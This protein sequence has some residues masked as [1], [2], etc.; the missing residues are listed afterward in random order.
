[1]R[2]AVISDIHSNLEALGA[3]FK[4]A[5]RLGIGEVVCLGD[6]VGYNAS[7]NECIDLLRQ[8]KVR[9]IMGNHDSRAAGL[10][11][12]TG[13]SLLAAEAMSWTLRALTPESVE[14]L[15]DLPQTLDVDHA[16]LAVH[17]W[18]NDADEYIYSDADAG[19]NFRLLKETPF[20]LCFFGHTHS[21]M[22]YVEGYGDFDAGH[23]E[24]SHAALSRDLSYLINPGSIGQPR[25][26]DPRA[27]FIVFDSQGYSVEFHRIDYDI[28]GAAQRI[29]DA[30]LPKRLAERLRLGW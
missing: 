23:E 14:Y 19:M 7:P 17:G 21:P 18:I 15:K 24:D 29:I 5:D 11:D 22:V 20:K 1:M 26:S 4:A 3:F 16:F 13:F 6:V 27:S 8:R 10:K 28:R 2:Y 30:G 25:D 9:S 12:L